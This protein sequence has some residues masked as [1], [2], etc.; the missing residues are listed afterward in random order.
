MTNIEMISL[1]ELLLGLGWR[2]I[3]WQLISATNETRIF[4]ARL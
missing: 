1:G 2:D 4:I 3:L